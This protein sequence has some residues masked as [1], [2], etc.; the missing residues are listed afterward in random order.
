MTQE[1]RQ[2]EK[3]GAPDAPLTLSLSMPEPL[4]EIKEPDAE[5]AM[6]PMKDE[7]R[8]AAVSQ[9]DHFIADLLHMDVTSDD[10]RARVDSAF[11]LGRKE[12]GD[13]A[14]LT[15]KFLEKNFV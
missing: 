3:I 2:P 7:T 4:K 11:R 12:I 6:V 9:A 5:A 13:S 14:L 15:G 1:S 10:F 8:N